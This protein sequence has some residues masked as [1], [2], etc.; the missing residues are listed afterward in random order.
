MTNLMR[1]KS[2]FKVC[3]FFEKKLIHLMTLVTS[4]EINFYFENLKFQND[5]G[6]FKLISSIEL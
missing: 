2:P 6:I 3:F 1:V 5:I 4:D